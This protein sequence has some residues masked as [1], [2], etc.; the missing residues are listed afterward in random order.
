VFTERGAGTPEEEKQNWYEKKGEGKE[1]LNSKRIGLPRKQKKRGPG[2]GARSKA[3]KV[4]YPT[5]MT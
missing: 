5:E 2:P 1:L 3:G 4:A